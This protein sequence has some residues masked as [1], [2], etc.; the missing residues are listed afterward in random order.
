MFV[1]HLE[2]ME[3]PGVKVVMNWESYPVDRQMRVRSHRRL[4]IRVKRYR[5]SHISS[6]AFFSRA[7]TVKAAVSKSLSK[8]ISRKI[9]STQ[10]S[11]PAED[12]LE[13]TD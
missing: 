7:T 6:F 9:V 11:L 4:T 2:R 1:R 3:I 10:L 8:T 12:G 5:I 13:L